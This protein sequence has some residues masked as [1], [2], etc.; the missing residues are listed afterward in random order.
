MTT[1]Y[2]NVYTTKGTRVYIKKPKRFS[3]T[4]I[5]TLSKHWITKGYNTEIIVQKPGVKSEVF[6]ELFKV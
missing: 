1:Y 3:L 5:K 4:T 2:I 6:T